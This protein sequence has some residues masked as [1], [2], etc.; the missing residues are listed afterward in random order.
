MIDA[1][2]VEKIVKLRRT[3]HQCPELGFEEY[4]TSSILA[5]ELRKLGIATKVIGTGV[6]GL[7][8]GKKKDKTI[9]L[10][11]DIDGLPIQ[12]E[13]K[14]LYCSRNKGKMHACGHDVHAA[15]VLGAAMIL[16]KEKDKLNGNIKLI[17]QPAEETAMTKNSGALKLIKKG[18]LDNPHVDA[19][20]S[21]HVHTSLLVGT[22]GVKYGKMLA[23]ADR[24]EITVRGKGG[25]GAYPHQ[26][27]DAIVISGYI[28]QGIQ[29]VVSRNIDPLEA[30]V[31]TIGVVK[32]GT[33]PNIIADEIHMIGT[34]RALD[35]SIREKMVSLLKRQVEGI[36]KSFGGTA[37]FIWKEGCP[38][39]INNDRLVNLIYE[40]GKE[41]LGEKNV[42]NISVP[43]MGGDDFA[44][45]AQR[46]PGAMFRLGITNKKRGIVYPAHHPH[47]YVD[48]GCL[49][50][51]PAVLA[52]CA[53]KWL[54]Q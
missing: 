3:L 16:I 33:A 40:S 13:N 38:P 17:F 18:V 12:E 51:G 28:I 39:L 46:I 31:V 37:E 7:I 14:I 42:V 2:L 22:I 48:E 1:K 24:I 50:I 10:R 15:S 9:A 45:Y 29:Q 5:K 49:S 32:G 25:H 54:N 6:V 41:L 21:I 30:A 53:I 27:I 35:Q 20:L 52:R 47:F 8:Q 23:S 11:A 4:E 26:T 34:M 43:V 19:I 44:F 36:A